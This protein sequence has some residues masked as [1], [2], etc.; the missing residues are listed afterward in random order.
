MPK[1][2][3]KTFS[4]VVNSAS[5]PFPNNQP[6]PPLPPPTGT[7]VNVST[8]SQLQAAVSNLKSNQTIMVAAGIY[9]LTT[10][11]FVPQGIN[12]IAIR[13][14]TGNA[15][16]VVLHGDATFVV[17]SPY[18]GTAIWGTGSG[19]TGTL[20]FGIWLGNVQGV[21]IADMTIKNFVDDAIILN[22]GVQSPLI[23]NVTMLDT[24]EQLLK[25]NPNSNGAGVPNGIVE[26]CTIGFTTK[27]PNNYTN[28]V[29]V[30]GG[31]NWVV[32]NNLFQNIITTNPLVIFSVGALTGPAVLFWQG[33]SNPTVVNNTFI[34]CQREIAFGL[35]PPTTITN[36]NTGGI[37]TNNMI[38]RSGGQHGDV[39]VA[40]WNSPNTEVAYNTI[41]LDGDYPN[42][43]EYRFTT[44]TGVKILYN[45]T[46]S[47]ITQRDG[48]VATVTG[49]V[50][51]GALPSWFVNKS[52]G[53]LHLTSS[54]TGAIGKGQFLSEVSTDYD[55]QTRPSTPCV[56]AD[57]L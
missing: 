54:A 28:G 26:Y 35:Q 56:G 47:A 49:N 19:I 10:T 4:L 15:G 37:I 48:A 17:N 14:A 24:G 38:Y 9:N 25:A 43:V 3:I 45:L 41:L 7:V 34:N 55:G 42:A 29:D 8:V 27:A 46:D 6:A 32:R 44:T 53:N 50:T 12:N 20:Q 23:H 51:S 31:S 40:V 2:A 1:Q 21:T 33:S 39:P 11:L 5:F 36:D 16:D 30:V 52:V 13:G 22:A 18:T 57:Q